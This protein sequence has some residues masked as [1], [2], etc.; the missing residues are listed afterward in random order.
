MLLHYITCTTLLS[1]YFILPCMK[2]ICLQ[3]FLLLFRDKDNA[4]FTFVFTQHLAQFLA[5]SIK[6]CW[7]VKLILFSI[8]EAHILHVHFPN[9][10]WTNKEHGEICCWKH[11]ILRVGLVSHINWEP[12]RSFTHQQ[13]CTMYHAIYTYVEKLRLFIHHLYIYNI[14]IIHINR[15]QNICSPCPHKAHTQ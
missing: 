7:R 6:A 10:H 15:K 5:H 4:L 3:M 8:R 12:P 11:T 2:A 13:I 14:Y 1:I 9:Q